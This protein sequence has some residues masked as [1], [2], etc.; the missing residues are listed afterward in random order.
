VLASGGV[1]LAVT[2]D[3]GL[4]ERLPRGT[5][6]AGPRWLL[7]ALDRHPPAG[8]RPEGGDRLPGIRGGSAVDVAR[9]DS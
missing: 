6:V 9:E 7:N 4:R 1:P 5:V 2:A 3:R 8:G